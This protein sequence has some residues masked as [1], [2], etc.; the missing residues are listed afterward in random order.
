MVIHCNQSDVMAFMEDKA[1]PSI[2]ENL[3]GCLEEVA[4]CP[5]WPDNVDGLY[6]IVSVDEI[7]SD[8]S[9]T[10]RPA[11][12]I[13]MVYVEYDVD[14]KVLERSIFDAWDYLGEEGHFHGEKEI[15]EEEEQVHEA[16]QADG[17]DEASA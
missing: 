2:W 7:C 6:E 11:F 1:E 9:G 8:E 17:G 15:E 12:H 13:I 5:K 16:E 4:R 3:K 10:C 14:G